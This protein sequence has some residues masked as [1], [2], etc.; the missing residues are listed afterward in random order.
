MPSLKVCD[1]ALDSKANAY[2]SFGAGFGW[3]DLP[4]DSV[5]VDVGGG[6]GSQCLALAKEYEHLQFVVQDREATITDADKVPVYSDHSIQP[7][8]TLSNSTGMLTSPKQS[9]AVVLD[10][11]VSDLIPQNQQFFTD[12]LFSSRLLHSSTGHGTR[13]IS[14]ANGP[15]RLVRQ[16]LYQDSV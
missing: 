8:F 15:P 3:K 6:V 2:K 12:S 10:C 7:R 9:K 1:R 4:E 11:V 14:T 16:V 5:V 13:C